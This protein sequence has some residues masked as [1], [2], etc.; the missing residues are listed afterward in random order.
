MR[1]DVQNR[2]QRQRLREQQILKTRLFGVYPPNQK[3]LEN[4]AASF[5]WFQTRCSLKG[6][7]EENMI[8]L[9]DVVKD[10]KI[11]GE[12]ANHSRY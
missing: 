12:H 2:V 8:L 10:A 6:P 7:I 1:Q 5:D 4:P 11:A 9:Q 3:I